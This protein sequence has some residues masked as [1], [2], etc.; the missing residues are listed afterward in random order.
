MTGPGVRT[1]ELPTHLAAD[2]SACQGLCCVALPF[3]AA[4]GFG[5]DKPAHEACRHLQGDHRCAIHGQLADRGFPGCVQFDCDGAGQR[6]TRLFAPRHWRDSAAQAAE[7]FEAFFLLRQAHAQLGLLATAGRLAPPGDLADRLAGQVQ[8]LDGWCEG[9]AAPATQPRAAEW[10]R[11]REQGQA[12]LAE[13][14]AAW[15]GARARGGP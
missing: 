8:A 2:C 1:A 11:L 9:L 15:P 5:F 6:V 13:F 14:G 7:L 3:D 12:L 4:Q 10:A